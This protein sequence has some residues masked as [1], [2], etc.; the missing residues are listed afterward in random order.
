MA[1]EK[2]SRSS[3]V[4]RLGRR[5]YRSL[6]EE[7]KFAGVALNVSTYEKM[8]CWGSFSYWAMPVCRDAR[9]QRPEMIE[10]MCITISSGVNTAAFRAAGRLRPELDWAMIRDDEIYRFLVQ[11]EIGHRQEN[12]D[13]IGIAMLEDPKV[14]DECMRKCSLVNEVLADRYAWRQIR[15]EAEIPLSENGRRLQNEVRECLDFFE[16]HAPKL[17]ACRPDRRLAEGA[18]C[19]VPDYMLAGKKRAAFLGPA[20]NRE[21]VSERGAYYN[22]CNTSNKQPLF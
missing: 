22:K 7:A 14:R 8:G 17:K 1:A 9:A 21:L 13:V 10:R 6:A 3:R 12:F 15:G 16:R 4:L 11:H 2:V 5:Q 19:D 18:Y 20:A